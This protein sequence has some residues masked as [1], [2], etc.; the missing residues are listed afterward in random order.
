MGFGKAG[1]RLEPAPSARCR[2]QGVLGPQTDQPGAKTLFAVKFGFLMHAPPTDTHSL[3]RSG[4]EALRR[5]DARAARE[6]FERI[7]ATGQ[8]D[9]SACVGLALRLSQS[10]GQRGLASR[11]RQGAALE[12]RNLRATDPQG[13]PPRGRRRRTR[14]VF[15]L[16][17][18]GQAAPPADQ[19]PTDLRKELDRAQA[20]CDHFA[21]EFETV[22]K[23]LLVGA[24][25]RSAPSVS[26]I[27]S[28]SMFGK[29]KIYFQDP[30][31]IFSGASADPVL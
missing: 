8:A 16:P 24:D 5:G 18:R 19:L 29:K 9:A 17:C 26:R 27:R 31:T 11:G 7:V 10:Q 20:M 15:V 14:R 12:P 30:A 28:I 3:A 21:E 1:N 25:G 23:N 22:L 2:R 4:V 6:S 13:R